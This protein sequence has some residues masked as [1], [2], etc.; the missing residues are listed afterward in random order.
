MELRCED[1]GPGFSAEALDRAFEP[2]FTTK[3][4]G[5]GTGLGLA[6][7]QRVVEDAGGGIALGNRPEGGAWVAVRLP[8]A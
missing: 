4:V 6:T 2:F 1:T 3:D 8:R 7:C 5:H